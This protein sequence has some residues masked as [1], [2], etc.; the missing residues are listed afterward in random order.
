MKL[1]KNRELLFQTS[2]T[3][4]LLVLLFFLL[5]ISNISKDLLQEQE[6]VLKEQEERIEKFETVIDSSGVNSDSLF[7]YINMYSFYNNENNLLND[8]IDSLASGKSL[9]EVQNQLEK[10][11][12]QLRKDLESFN[13]ILKNDK[14]ILDKSKDLAQL[15][16]KLNEKEDEIAAYKSLMENSMKAGVSKGDL[17]P[18]EEFQQEKRLIN[19]EQ[20]RKEAEDK[21]L[22]IQEKL[23]QKNMELASLKDQVPVKS[24]DELKSENQQ[25]KNNID[26]LQK[27][28]SESQFAFEQFKDQ[29][30]M[31]E[32]APACDL[33][34]GMTGS[35]YLFQLDFTVQCPPL[36]D[37]RGRPIAGTRDCDDD[38][39]KN[40]YFINLKMFYVN[41][42]YLVSKTPA[43]KEGQ[44]FYELEFSDIRKPVGGSAV[45][46]NFT[47]FGPLLNRLDKIKTSRD[48]NQNDAFCEK[49]WKNK[50]KGF[51]RECVYSAYLGKVDEELIKYISEIS[52]IIDEYVFFTTK[53]MND[54]S[55]WVSI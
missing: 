53:W 9:L 46:T 14:E 38:P 21:L 40:K 11:N 35:Q 8:F 30:S 42:T 43:I 23:N 3:E 18:E 33:R 22:E 54:P 6:V 45:N 47:G 12:L 28:L 29:Q 10:E 13:N 50:T 2:I 4:T 31:G 44:A 26:E 52:S 51:C 16:E 34:H 55:K 32:N 19:A 41:N 39:S 7:T 20:E 36:Y 48:I 1:L 15:E 37:R 27:K 49:N 5:F 17:T 25:L 24:S